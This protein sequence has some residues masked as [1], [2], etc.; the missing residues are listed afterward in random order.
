MLGSELSL[1]LIADLCDVGLDAHVMRQQAVYVVNGRDA[2]VVH[3]HM[4][5]NVSGH[6]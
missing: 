6:D 5:L 1:A 2:Q 3:L 4:V